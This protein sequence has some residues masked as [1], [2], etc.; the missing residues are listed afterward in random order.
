MT[1]YSQHVA[2]ARASQ[3]EPASPEQ[4][5]N[6]AGGYTFTVDK[7][8]QLDRFLI[9]GT[10]GGSYYA[11]EKKLTKENAAVVSNCLAE[12]PVRTVKQIVEVSKGGRAPKNDQAIFALALAASHANPEARKAALDQLSSVCRIGTHLFQFVATVK[13]F[14]GFGAG[15]RKALARW[16]TEKDP[17][18]LAYQLVKYQSRVTEE[19]KKSS[20]FTHRD[21]LRLCHAQSSV[22]LANAALRWAVGGMENMLART[23]VRNGVETKYGPVDEQFIPKLLVGVQKLKHE[24]D[25]EAAVMLIRDYQLTHEMV[26]NELK[27][28]PKVWA[29][30]LPHMPL[31]AMI[32]N[33]GKM[34]AI[35]L[36]RPLSEASK[37]V[38]EKLHNVDAIRE[39]RLH[40]LSIL[41]ALNTYSAGRGVKGSL[42][43]DVNPRVK[44]AL[45]DAFH[46]AFQTIVPTG[47]NILIALDVSASMT[48]STISGMTGITPRIGSAAM[49]MVTARTEKNFHVVAF[50]SGGRVSSRWGT[51]GFRPVNVSATEKLNTVINKIEQIPAGGTDCS[52]PMVWAKQNKIEVDCF[53]IYTDS[54]TWAGDVHPHV[55]LQQYRQ[56]MGR[57]ARVA[58]VGMVSNGFSIANPAD[59]GMM[60]FVGFDTAAPGIMADFARGQF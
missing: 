13:E 14:R 9:L 36:L 50:S 17:D 38:Q 40:P 34:S 30:M 22:P 32:R 58:V 11:T 27:N 59:R 7:W 43:W 47:K 12:D 33:L 25:A 46:L 1:R 18:K 16:Y 2:P 37:L 41:V 26:P 55:A 54:E 60:D 53:Q 28:E 24:T 23:V 52:L 49:A 20:T 48:W 8:A 19:G 15:L 29:A 4:V 10:V 6:S 5:E 3:T 21:I 42:T 57:D 39:S 35:G 45:D 51:L 31:G 56:A 44:D